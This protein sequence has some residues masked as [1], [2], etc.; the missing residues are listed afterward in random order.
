M[1]CHGKLLLALSSIML[2]F[3]N[4]NTKM[5]SHEHRRFCTEAHT[6]F[7]APNGR[8]C[9]FRFASS[10]G[11]QLNGNDIMTK[12]LSL[13]PPEAVISALL[14]HCAGNSPVTGEFPAQRPVTRSFDVSLICAWIDAWVNN[15]ESG[16]LRRH[17]AHY[18]VIVM[19]AYVSLLWLFYFRILCSPFPNGLGDVLVVHPPNHVKSDFSKKKNQ[20]LISDDIPHYHNCACLVPNMWQTT[21]M[22]SSN[23]N[24]FRV[25]GPLWGELTGQRWIPHAKA[26][27]AELWCFLWSTLE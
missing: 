27:D 21:M 16:D 22:T 20:I 7:S 3:I 10:A 12:F 19:M 2:R 15:R 11:C 1:Y 5:I 13:T 26:S 14:A 9:K 18:D 17:R 23:G 25:S 6:L 24:I 8:C 4:K